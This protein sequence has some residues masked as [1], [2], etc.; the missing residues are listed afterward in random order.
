MDTQET[1]VEVTFRCIMCNH[2]ETVREVGMTSSPWHC[3]SPMLVAALIPFS[4]DE[5]KVLEAGGVVDRGDG[6]QYLKVSPSK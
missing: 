6:N 1:Q 3:L 5:S 4:P 2:E